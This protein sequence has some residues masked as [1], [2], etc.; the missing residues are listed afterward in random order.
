MSADQAQSN[1]TP[2]AIQIE[3][4]AQ[5]GLVPQMQ[6]MMKALWSS[7]VRSKIFALAGAI[8]IVVAATAYGQI[9][10]NRWNK[11]F[12]DAL[13]HH[14]LEDFISQLGIFGVIAGALL[15]LNV[16]QK[17][18]GETLKVKLREGLAK[19]LI[20]AWLAPG[21]AFRL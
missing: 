11:P 8:F 20:Q 15:V 17:W 10:L 19:D 5:S 7:S 12:Y 16:A 18:L 4:A 9:R 13:S 6:M 14:D 3:D 1:E 21:R 2:T